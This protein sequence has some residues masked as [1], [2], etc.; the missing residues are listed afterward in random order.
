[1]CILA[2]LTSDFFKKHF[3]QDGLAA[4]LNANSSNPNALAKLG[5]DGEICFLS[6]TYVLSGIFSVQ[7]TKD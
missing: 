3:L 4:K 2:A 5:Y 1:M 6:F 7:K